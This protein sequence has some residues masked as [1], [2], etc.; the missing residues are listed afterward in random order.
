MVTKRD[1]LKA[2]HAC[3]EIKITR[4]TSRANINKALAAGDLFA[5]KLMEWMREIR[6]QRHAEG[7]ENRKRW[8]EY[9]K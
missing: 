9:M 2:L 8:R 7:I 5:S 3:E 1:V 4:Y 6:T